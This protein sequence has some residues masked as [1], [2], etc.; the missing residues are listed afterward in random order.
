LKREAQLKVNLGV[1][2]CSILRDIILNNIQE[3]N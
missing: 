2:S 3:K 1:I